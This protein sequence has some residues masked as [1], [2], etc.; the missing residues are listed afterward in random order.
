MK[1][2]VTRLVHF[3]FCR[4]MVK[5]FVATMSAPSFPVESKQILSHAIDL[6][7]AS[8]KFILPD[9]GRLYD[10]PDLRALDETVPLSL[11]YKFIAL[12]YE[13]PQYDKASPKTIV[14]ARERDDAIVVMPAIWI[15]ASGT[16][17]LMPEFALPRVGYLDRSSKNNGYVCIKASFTNKNIPQADYADE[18]GALLCFLN[19]LQCGNVVTQKSPPSETRKAL[20]S[21]KALPYDEYHILTIDVPSDQPQESGVAGSHRSPREHLRRGHIRRLADGRKIWVNAAGIA[22]G[23]GCG[24][25]SKDYLVRSVKAAHGM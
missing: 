12:E 11:P 15:A 7:K 22:A 23:R 9:G 10:D 16:W 21:S 24:V 25:I 3:D 19:I 14:F 8:Q 13:R 6:S 5:Q 4:S 17:G 1:K 18:I 2:S 20:S